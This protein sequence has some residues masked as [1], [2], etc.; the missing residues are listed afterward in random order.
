M[1]REIEPELREYQL[2]LSPEKIH[3]LLYYAAMFIGDSQT[4]TSEAAI[5]GTPAVKCNSLA[6]RLSVPNEIEKKYGLCF[7]FTPGQFPAM[8]NKIEELLDFR[9]IKI[10][11]RKKSE[12]LISEKIDVTSFMVWL[13]ENYPG[14]LKMIK[15]NSNYALSI[16]RRNKRSNG[17]MES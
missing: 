9:D 6:G 10:Q 17:V 13:I 11:W 3:S 7:S 4:M 2:M 14:S 15:E 1:E 5:L 8:V 16:E 12:K